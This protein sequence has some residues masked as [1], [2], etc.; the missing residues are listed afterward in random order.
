LV[1]GELAISLTLLAGAGLLLRSFG[2][3][4]TVDPG[5][6]PSH[7][8]TFK[9]NLPEAAY[10]DGNRTAAFTDELLA[11]IEAVPGVRSAAVTFLQPLSGADFS[12]SF[13]VKGAPPVSA[14]DEPSAQLRVASHKYFATMG[15][16]LLR[17]RSFEFS[18]RRGSPPVVIL[19]RAAE[20]KFFPH[21]D[22]IGKELK[23]GARM[24]YDKLQGEVIGIVGD[25]HDFGLDI[26][27]PP[28]AYLLADQA[29]ISEMNVV[30]RAAAEPASLAS[31]VRE[32]VLTVDK[33]LPITGMKTMHEV[34]AESLAAR[35]FYMVLLAIFALIAV[36]LAAVGVYGVMAYWV[37]RRTQEIGVR[38]ALGAEHKQVLAM[39]LFQGS[40]L[41]AIG[42]G[43]GLVVTTA[44]SRVLA[45]LLF[46]VS[47]T[48]PLILAGVAMSLAWVATIAGYLPARRILRV[49]PMVALRYE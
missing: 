16:P 40:R 23:F 7:L 18:D 42:I 15:I 13:T 46:G 12:S 28:D 48:D 14:S 26:E 36:S 4:L 3:L 44:A 19:S 25:V 43:I 39:L 34:M 6:D 11:K 9:L 32:Q 2:N 24:G 21:G 41:V 5:F 17:G 31:A 27:P 47:A 35:R 45:G 10:S 8:L 30:V 20:R 29:G 33:N 22:A 37:S 1:A 49:D 38:L